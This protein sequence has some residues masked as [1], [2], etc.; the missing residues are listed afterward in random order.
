MSQ[1]EA[2]NRCRQ[3]FSARSLLINWTSKG[4]RCRYYGH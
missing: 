1:S 4:W 3:Q 2:F